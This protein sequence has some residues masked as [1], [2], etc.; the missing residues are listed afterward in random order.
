MVL[1]D[2]ELVRIEYILGTLFISTINPMKLKALIA[3]LR[4]AESVI[5]D[6]ERN[7][8]VVNPLGVAE[9]RRLAG[10]LEGPL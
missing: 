4:A 3:R 1:T 2:D 9:W 7:L 5:L 10:K 8:G 6:S